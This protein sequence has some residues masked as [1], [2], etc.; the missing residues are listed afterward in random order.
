[1]TR[2]ALDLDRCSQLR[3]L[4][5][6][7][8]LAHFTN[9]I[10]VFSTSIDDDGK[11]NYHVIAYGLPE[12]TEDK[13][14]EFRHAL[15][16]DLY[17]IWLDQRLNSKPKQ[18]LF[19]RRVKRNRKSGKWIINYRLRILTMLWKPWISKIPSRKPKRNC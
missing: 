18:V 10:E 3:L 5:V 8:N 1:M 11:E 14:Y 15:H 7:Y 9:K 13:F 2:L 17:R 4:N 16:D 12:L 19:N 6:F